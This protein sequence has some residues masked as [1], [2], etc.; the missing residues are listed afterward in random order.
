LEKKEFTLAPGEKRDIILSAK[1]GNE[2]AG[3]YVIPGVLEWNYQ[4]AETT[5]SK[6][7]VDK[8]EIRITAGGYLYSDTGKI[9]WQ[10]LPEYAAAYTKVAGDFVATV[11]FMYQDAS[12]Q[13]ALAGILSS[14]NMKNADNEPGLVVLSNAPKYGSMGIWRADG[15]GDCKTEQSICFSTKFGYWLRLE[16]CGS[17]FKAY[18]GPDRVNWEEITAWEVPDA[19]EVQDVGLFAYA[20][21]VKNEPGLAIFEDFVIEK[22]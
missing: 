13:Y 19:K 16:R 21:S 10:C 9:E 8:N 11:H 12:G 15:D 14:N 1:N 4:L 2:E 7:E 18:T 22:K 5:Y 17:T 3:A 20:N 6:Y